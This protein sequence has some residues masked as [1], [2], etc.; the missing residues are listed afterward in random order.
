[1]EFAILPA[2]IVVFAIAVIYAVSVMTVGDLARRKLNLNSEFTRKIVHMF[3]GGAIWTI[4]FF[5]N[6]W[7]A[8]LV[9]VLF[10]LMTSMANT[11]RFGR[12]FAAMARPEDVENASIRGPFWYAVS[13]T[14]LTGFFMLTG[15]EAIFFLGAAG[16]HIMMFGDGM[17]A[18][19]GMKYGKNHTVVIF[20]SKR[21][22]QG[23]LALF[24]FGF[25]GSLLSFW[26]FGTLFTGYEAFVLGGAILW[27]EMIVLALVGG[28]TATLV[29]LVS[30][31][32]TDNITVPIIACA[33][34]FLVGMALGV[35][36]V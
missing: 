10:V 23:C 34:M 13:V 25:I 6:P 16:I 11:E 8:T 27:T 7:L 3:G 26:Y 12:F 20:G 9:G 28:T 21:S 22:L 1:V 15:N 19:V 18:P 5:P 24:I 14:A 35:V 2:D 17:S 30:P 36:V 32:G 33:V 4:P 29:E 31:K